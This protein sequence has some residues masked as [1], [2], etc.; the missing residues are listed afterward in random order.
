MWSNRNQDLICRSPI[1]THLANAIEAS[2]CAYLGSSCVK[3]R[4]AKA[5][6]KVFSK[7]LLHR[8]KPVYR[9]RIFIYEIHLFTSRQSASH[10]LT[11]RPSLSVT[12][13][14]GA[15]LVANQFANAL[16]PRTT[17]DDAYDFVIV[18]GG[19][20][21]L[22]LGSRLSEDKNHTVLV[23]E[24]GGNGDDYRKRI[25]AFNYLIARSHA[26][27]LTQIQIHRHILISTLYGQRL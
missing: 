7:V 27:F 12:Q 18:G 10:T 15:S 5:H 26:T 11:M 13:I 19:Q 21:G 22:V 6:Y 23:L 8:L 17:I 4:I 25:G 2:G 1:W 16:S 9:D 24:S 20:A 3:L 14:V